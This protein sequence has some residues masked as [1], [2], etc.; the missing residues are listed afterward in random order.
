MWHSGFLP[1]RKLGSKEVLL[2]VAW[3]TLM[4]VVGSH[5]VALMVVVALDWVA[6]MVMV[7]SHWV[8]LL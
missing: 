4:M 1:K 7:T 5:R 3:E 8:L 2:K 6:L